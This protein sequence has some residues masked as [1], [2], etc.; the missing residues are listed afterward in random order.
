MVIAI[1]ESAYSW[2]I[3]I[4]HF[5]SGLENCEKEGIYSIENDFPNMKF[6]YSIDNALIAK[7]RSRTSRHDYSLN[8]VN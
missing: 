6:I 7:N 3:D 2:K 4:V 1:G 5:R 8:V